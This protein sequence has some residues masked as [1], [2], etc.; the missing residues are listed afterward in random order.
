[1]RFSGDID[2]FT[3]EAKRAFPEAGLYKANKRRGS[4]ALTYEQL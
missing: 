1:M 4:L 2:A 3:S